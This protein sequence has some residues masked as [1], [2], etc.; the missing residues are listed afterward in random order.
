M[1]KPELPALTGIRFYAALLV[2]LSHVPLIPGMDQMAGPRLLFNSGVVGVSFFFVLSGFI[3]TYNYA[4]VFRDSLGRHDYRKF[5]WDRLTKIYPVHCA[6]TLAMIPLQYLSPNLPLDWRAAPVHLLLAQCFWPSPEPPFY[7]YLN[8]PSWSISCEWFFYLCAPVVLFALARR[9]LGIALIA[10]VAVYA[11]VLGWFLEGGSEI[12]KLFYVSWFAPSRL[13]EFVV[14]VV[15]ARLYL[16]SRFPAGRR[17]A[18][19]LQLAGLALILTGAL[20]RAQAPWPF[21]GGLLYVPGSAALV[22]G[23]AQNRGLLASHLGRRSLQV[24]GTA[25]FSFYLLHAPI[26]RGLRMAW[27]RFGWSVESWSGFLVTAITIFL[28]VQV[29]AIAVCYLYEIPLQRWLRKFVASRPSLPAEPA[30][31]GEDKPLRARAAGA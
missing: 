16:S 26:L 12:S 4:D 29:V 19:T 23:L 24:L 7:K 5:V 28:A 11:C 22:Y 30:A 20:Y 27:L 9:Y 17:L 25:S 13:P 6:V 10:L 2:F 1:R 3:L 21:W 18:G 8:V 14:G 31:R 15:V